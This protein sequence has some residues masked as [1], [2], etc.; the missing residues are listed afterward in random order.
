MREEIEIIEKTVFVTEDGRIFSD[1]V[2]AEIHE[3]VLKGIKKY[4]EHCART[5]SVMV[6]KGSWGYYEQWT[7]EPCTKCNGKGYLELK[8]V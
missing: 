7:P 6:D 3:D 2:A 8:W 5:G 4:C 1:K